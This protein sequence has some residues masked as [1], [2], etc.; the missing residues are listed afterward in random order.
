MYCIM[1]SSSTV[2]PGRLGS[3]AGRVPKAAHE[4]LQ[5]AS[6]LPP[7]IA[8]VNSLGDVKQHY[9]DVSALTCLLASERTD[10]GVMR[11]LLLHTELPMQMCSCLAQ[12]LQHLTAAK[13]EFNAQDPTL[14]ILGQLACGISMLFCPKAFRGDAV[15]YTAISAVV[16]ASGEQLVWQS[17]HWSSCCHHPEP[18]TSQL[19]RPHAAAAAFHS[20][21]RACM[22]CV[23][24][25]PIFPS[26]AFMSATQCCQKLVG[27]VI[28]ARIVQA[29][30][31]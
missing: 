27:Y 28:G 21:T 20:S 11:H 16:R 24:L 6:F 10:T 3:N 31:L 15:V 19:A 18:C 26:A 8:S 17:F 22:I 4:L 29:I 14:A 13:P 1:S 9:R 7:L 12:L 25:A 2:N 5:A 23:Q 30:G